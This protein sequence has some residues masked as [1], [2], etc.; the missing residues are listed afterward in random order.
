MFWFMLTLFLNNQVPFQGR[1]IVYRNMSYSF[2][3]IT[4]KYYDLDINQ[5]INSTIYIWFIY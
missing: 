4:F 5:H 1:V 2:A 3:S